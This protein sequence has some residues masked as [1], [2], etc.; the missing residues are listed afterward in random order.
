[1]Q[2]DIKLIQE[3][4]NK[5]GRQIHRVQTAVALYRNEL[6]LLEMGRGDLSRAKQYE[7]DLRIFVGQN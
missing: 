1:M 7:S 5:A 4:L 3:A 6:A 2:E